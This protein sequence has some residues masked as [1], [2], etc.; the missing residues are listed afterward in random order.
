MISDDEFFD[1]LYQIDIDD[2]IDGISISSVLDGD[3]VPLELVQVEKPDPWVALNLRH[4]SE[5]DAGCTYECTPEVEAIADAME[6]DHEVVTPNN[7]VFVAVRKVAGPLLKL[8]GTQGVCFAPVSTG[9]H[10]ACCDSPI[11]SI[12]EIEF[13]DEP[14]LAVLFP[15]DNG[16]KEP[17]LRRAPVEVQPDPG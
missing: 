16:R 8:L 11:C 12:Q 6:S 9:V 1:E 17:S 15:P 13:D 3:I 10:G 7:F 4:D 14:R 5:E 2:I